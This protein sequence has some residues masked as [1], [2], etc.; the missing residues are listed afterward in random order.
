VEININ[1]YLSPYISPG[2]VVL[3]AC[4]NKSEPLIKDKK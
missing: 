3:A 4:Q 1:V 2:S